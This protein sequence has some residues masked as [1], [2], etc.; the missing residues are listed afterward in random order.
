MQKETN[1]V[2][3]HGREDLFKNLLRI[4]RVVVRHYGLSRSG[5]LIFSTL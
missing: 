3:P 2:D 1:D 5:Y 4:Q